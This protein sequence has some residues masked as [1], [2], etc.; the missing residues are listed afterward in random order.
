MDNQF[1]WRRVWQVG[2][3]DGS[4]DYSNLFLQ[5]GLVAVGAVYDRGPYHADHRPY[6]T[7]G[8]V[9]DD[10]TTKIWPLAAAVSVRPE[11]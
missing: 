6:D 9:D 1:D 8:A 11:R 3:G 7:K 4:R 2:C 5:F 10:S